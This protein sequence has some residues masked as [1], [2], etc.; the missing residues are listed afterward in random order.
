M[1]NVAFTKN[2][3][4]VSPSVISAHLESS[5]LTRKEKSSRGFYAL[6]VVEETK[7]TWN[8]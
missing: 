6:R 7:I 2:L 3:L 1:G 4:I 8:R 5:L